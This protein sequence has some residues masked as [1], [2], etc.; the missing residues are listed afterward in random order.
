MDD[1]PDIREIVK[2][3]LKG[4]EFRILEAGD[5][6]AAMEI[7]RNESPD[8][9]ISDIYMPKMD[10]LKLSE[11]ILTIDNTAKIIITS[12]VDGHRKPENTSENTKFFGKPFSEEFTSY[13]KKVLSS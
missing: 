5:G 4:S 12:G 6:C 7:F 13:V 10:G 3:S 8:L 11:E 2:G 9:V 1:E